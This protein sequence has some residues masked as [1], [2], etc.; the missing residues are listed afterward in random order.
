MAFNIGNDDT[1][2]VFSEVQVD[3][4]EVPSLLEIDETMTVQEQAE[5]KKKLIYDH[6]GRAIN[7]WDEVKNMTYDHMNQAIASEYLKDL[8]KEYDDVHVVCPIV[9]QFMVHQKIFSA[10]AYNKVLEK[11]VNTKD[12]YFELQA[13]YTMYLH[14]EEYKRH[15][16][17]E[18]DRREA[19]YR[20]N[21]MLEH[22][23]KKDSQTS[24]VNKKFTD[25]KN[26]IEK[27]KMQKMKDELVLLAKRQ[28]FAKK[29]NNH[30]KRDN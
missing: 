1:N 3:N 21:K 15:N 17:K 6:V 16:N 12:D 28:A 19:F 24:E 9:L 13:N 14:M 7:A 20:K 11:K 5:Y 26:M 25:E 18:M 30:T 23:I 29:L 27:R 10:K 22:L 8:R 2:Y 4:D